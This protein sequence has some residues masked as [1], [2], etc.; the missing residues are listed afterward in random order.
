[1]P[2]NKD[3]ERNHAYLISAGYAWRVGD[4][5]VLGVPDSSAEKSVDIALVGERFSSVSRRQ[6]SFHFNN[7]K[8]AWYVFDE[9]STNGMLVIHES[10]GEERLWAKM[11]GKK[12]EC[13]IID[14]DALEVPGA[15][16]FTF[17]MGTLRESAANSGN[18]D[19]VRKAI[20]IFEPVIRRYVVSV[21]KTE[22]PEN[23]SWW[24][25]GVLAH[26]TT[27][28]ARFLSSRR[29]SADNLDFS[30]LMHILRDD[31]RSERSFTHAFG[32]GFE[33][34]TLILEDMMHKTSG[35]SGLSDSEIEYLEARQTLYGILAFCKAREVAASRS[36]ISRLETIVTQF[37]FGR[38]ER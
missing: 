33:E 18:A 9:D 12:S 15:P 13:E 19:C 11:P 26:V 22:Y 21:L 38:E 6:A 14:G 23:G 30:C 24:N 25:D 10:G 1:M 3:D 5:Y 28:Q 37:E 35:Q 8:S 4:G 34:T 29:S 20:A 31:Q 17:R 27:N 16:R 2:K 7:A 32:Y 36:D